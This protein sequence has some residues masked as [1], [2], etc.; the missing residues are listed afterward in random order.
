M[1]VDWRLKKT[2]NNQQPSISNHQ[3]KWTETDLKLEVI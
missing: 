1:I 3:S 2:I